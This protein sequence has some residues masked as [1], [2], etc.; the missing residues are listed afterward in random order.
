[1]KIPESDAFPIVREPMYAEAVLIVV[2]DKPPVRLNEP[3]RTKLPIYAFVV[4]IDVVD[5][6][7]P[8]VAKPVVTIVIALKLFIK[9]I[10]VE[11]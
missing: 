11:I 6:P 5:I 7:P 9:P 1:M 3:P 2:V 10:D 8:R 4:L